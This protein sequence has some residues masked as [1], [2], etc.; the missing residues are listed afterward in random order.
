[1][2]PTPPRHSFT[3]A[4]GDRPA[5]LALRYLIAPLPQQLAA[6]VFRPSGSQPLSNSG[7]RRVFP[8][9]TPALWVSPPILGQVLPQVTPALGHLGRSVISDAQPSL[10]LVHFGA[11]PLCQSSTILG[12]CIFVLFLLF[13]FVFPC[14]S[15][16]HLVVTMYLHIS[17]GQLSTSRGLQ[18]NN[19]IVC[20][21][22]GGMALVPMVSINTYVEWTFQTKQKTIFAGSADAAVCAMRSL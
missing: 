3:L 22:S 9:A 7:S 15:S 10:A 1:M 18:A 5:A 6:L 14:P 20:H 19:T 13:V 17:L 12:G 16:Y 8:S 2:L 11:G 4:L 21:F